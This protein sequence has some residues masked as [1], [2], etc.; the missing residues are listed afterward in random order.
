MGTLDLGQ[1]LC[2]RI[3]P[4][5]QYVGA[6]ELS[7]AGRAKRQYRVCSLLKIFLSTRTNHTDESRM[8]VM[9]AISGLMVGTQ[10]Y[11]ASDRPL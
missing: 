5:P 3:P 6:G 9:S 7:D 11:R 1:Q 10:Y 8:W 2:G 4:R